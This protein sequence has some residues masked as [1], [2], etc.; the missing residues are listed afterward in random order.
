MEVFPCTPKASPL[1]F[2]GPEYP[3]ETL[4]FGLRNVLNQSISAFGKGL[5]TTFLT[6]CDT[7]GYSQRW[8]G[9][10]KELGNIVAEGRRTPWAGHP[11]FSSSVALSDGVRSSKWKEW[12]TCVFYHTAQVIQTHDLP[13]FSGDN[14]P[15]LL[16]VPYWSV[17][18][19]SRD[20]LCECHSRALPAS[21]NFTRLLTL[22]PPHPGTSSLLSFKC[23]GFPCVGKLAPQKRDSATRVP[24]QA[25]SCLLSPS[26]VASHAVLTR[27]ASHVTAP[28]LTVPDT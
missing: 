26:L 28:L 8:A 7:K 6:K 3:L 4:F 1:A 17:Q 24:V 5:L 12:Q 21:S 11:E 15:G 9:Q 10:G 23:Q 16:D 27:P 14:G 2:L 19:C 22:G 25:L 20:F 18:A 13:P